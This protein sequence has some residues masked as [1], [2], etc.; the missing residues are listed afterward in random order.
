MTLLKLQPLRRQTSG[1]I[2]KLTMMTRSLKRNYK[3]TLVIRWNKPLTMSLKKRRQMKKT[4]VKM[5]RWSRLTGTRIVKGKM[6]ILLKICR[7]KSLHLVAP[8]ARN[9]Q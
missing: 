1:S 2:R 3:R 4:R 5:S 8:L 7:S 9:L 6:S